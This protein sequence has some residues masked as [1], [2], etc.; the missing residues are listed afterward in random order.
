LRRKRC[1]ADIGGGGK[2]E[3]KW[4]WLRQNVALTAR[5]YPLRD[6]AL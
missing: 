3:P 2:V 6:N 4:A 5:R 1:C